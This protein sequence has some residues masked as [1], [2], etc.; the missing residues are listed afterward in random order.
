RHRSTL[1]SPEENHVSLSFRRFR[2]VVLA[3]G[4]LALRPIAVHAG[5]DLIPQAQPIF[6]GALGTLDRPFAGPGDF[7]EVH[8]RPTICDTASPGLPTSVDDVD[9]TLLFEPPGGPRRAVVLT[10]ASCA[11]ADFG[12]R[13]AACQATPNMSAGGVTCVQMNAAGPFDM[14]IVERDSIPRLRFR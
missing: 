1:R 12:A 10:T 8:V 4:L 11:D 7:V 5:C 14:D 9:V 3:L 13:L 2:T 6:R